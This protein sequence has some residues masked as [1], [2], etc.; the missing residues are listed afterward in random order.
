MFFFCFF[1]DAIFL[2]V[3]SAF[4]QQGVGGDDE[5]EQLLRKE[6]KQISRSADDG[7]LI[8]FAISKS[9]QIMPPAAREH[10]LALSVFPTAFTLP[11][12][13]SQTKM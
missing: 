8:E 5:V 12:I 10:L 9:Y 6:S 13:S 2:P 11:G 7:R 3:R 4:A 1:A